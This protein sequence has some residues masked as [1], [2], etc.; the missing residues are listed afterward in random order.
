MFI[1]IVLIQRLSNWN[2]IKG[3]CAKFHMDCREGFFTLRFCSHSIY[4]FHIYIYME[5][6]SR[7]GLESTFW[8]SLC[9]GIQVCFSTA[10]I[11]LTISTYYSPQMKKQ[12][13]QKSRSSRPIQTIYQSVGPWD[14][15]LLPLHHYHL[16]RHCTP[17]S[18]NGAMYAFKV[19]EKTLVIKFAKIPRHCSKFKTKGWCP[20]PGYMLTVNVQMYW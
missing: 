5:F 3:D 16:L 6:R 7:P 8:V 12:E 10:A 9:Y 11:K 20:I 17:C 4:T 2:K 13:L 15:S 1:G 18:D 14:I 19:G